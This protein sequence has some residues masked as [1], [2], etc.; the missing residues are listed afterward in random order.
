METLQE[1]IPF[2]KEMINQKPN[3][4]MLKVYLVGSVVAVLGTVLGLVQTVCQSFSSV[5]DAALDAELAKLVA[6]EL[7]EEERRRKREEVPEVVEK[8]N[9][10][11]RKREEMAGVAHRSAAT[12]LHAS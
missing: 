6:R 3:R 4:G 1:I 7:R 2:A 9:Y 10:G 12:R 8:T 11:E 5:D